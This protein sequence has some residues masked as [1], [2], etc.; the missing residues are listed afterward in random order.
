M[1]RGPWENLRS[2]AQGPQPA[3]AHM[4]PHPPQKP[5]RPQ[6]AR[7]VP[8]GSSHTLA[9]HGHP[10]C[11]QSHIL[12]DAPHTP[13]TDTPTVHTAHTPQTPSDTHTPMDTPTA[14]TLHTLTDTP[15]THPSHWWGNFVPGGASK[16]LEAVAVSPTHPSCCGRV[17]ELTAAGGP[18]SSW[19]TGPSAPRHVCCPFPPLGLLGT[20]F[21]HFLYS[22]QEH[23]RAY[24]PPHPP[25]YTHAPNTHAVQKEY[26]SVQDP[27]AH[28][29]RDRS[30]G[31]RS[32]GSLPPC[33]G[34][35]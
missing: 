28:L 7:R 9:A 8:P 12:T 13:H 18:R 10:H 35:S 15:Q 26:G 20:S 14:H 25:P 11:T 5:H 6:C 1:D 2:P 31:L 3:C 29:P 34:W 33:L 24:T 23:V 22:G 30:L 17:L 21:H 32:R 16:L 4:C 27:T 19:V